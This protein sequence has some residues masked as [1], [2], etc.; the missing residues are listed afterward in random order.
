MSA[1]LNGIPAILI[2]PLRVALQ[3]Q[4]FPPEMVRDDGT[5]NAAGLLA[6]TF[7][8]I[9]FKSALWPT[10]TVD[11]RQLLVGKSTPSPFMDWVKPTVVLK[12]RATQ[13]QTVIAPYGAHPGGTVIPVVG[14][15]VGLVG[16]GY[17]LAKL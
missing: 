10:V 13:Q 17:L 7:D 14:V 3:S 12:S 4:G 9:E 5:L 1:Q 11:T 8:T 6:T 16:L 15:V 2:A